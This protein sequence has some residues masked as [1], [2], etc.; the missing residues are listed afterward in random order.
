MRVLS[1]HGYILIR[2]SS[3]ASVDR[4]YAPGLRGAQ[5]HKVPKFLGHSNSLVR[6]LRSIQ[7]AH[8]PKPK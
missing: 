1:R 3:G 8:T 5:G 6:G 7:S 4:E 2:A